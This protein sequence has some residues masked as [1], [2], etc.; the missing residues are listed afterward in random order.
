[1]RFLKNLSRVF[2]VLSI[3]PLVIC[4]CNKTSSPKKYLIATDLKFPPFGM[5]DSNNNPLGIDIELFSEIAKDQNF[6]YEF[7]NMEFSSGV[8]ALESEKIDG[9]MSSVL[10]T[11]RRKLKYDF[12]NPYYK[13]AISMGISENKNISNYDELKNRNV[14]CKTASAG[15]NFAEQISE[16]YNFKVKYFEESSTIYEEIKSGN[17]IACFEDY[18]S[19]FY[20]IKNKT[21][22]KVA[23]RDCGVDAECGFVVLKGKNAELIK[24]FNVGL[25]HLKESGKYKEII[26]KYGG[27]N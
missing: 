15:G 20:A 25:A 22:I 8:A 1:M 3:L 26:D 24:K 13:S 7:K 11:E 18:P 16:K 10:I 2:I 17:S 5:V 12:S 27:V 23:I 9:L 14:A 6:S 19:L 4:A 21:G